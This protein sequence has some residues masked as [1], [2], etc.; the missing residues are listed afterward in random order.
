MDTIVKVEIRLTKQE[1]GIFELASKLSGISF[2]TW[3]RESLREACINE[4]G[5]NGYSTAPYQRIIESSRD[6]LD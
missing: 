2:E 1:R 4:F 3:L 5:R 6:L